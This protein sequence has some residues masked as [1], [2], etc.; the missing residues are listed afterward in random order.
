MSR[1]QLPKKYLKDTLTAINQ[2]VPNKSSNPSLMLVNLKTEGDKLTLSGTNQVVDISRDLS[3]DIEGQVNVN[4]PCEIFTKNVSVL[5]SELVELNFEENNLNIRSGP[6]KSNLTLSTAE[7]WQL[8][9]EFE[10]KFSIDG[11]ELQK[12][13]NHTNYAP[14]VAEYQ[15]VFRGVLFE[16]TGKEFNLVTTDGFRLAKYSLTESKGFPELKKVVF[17]DALQKI[18]KQIS[19]E[20]QLAFSNSHMLIESGNQKIKLQLMEGEY[21]DYKKVIP[22]QYV[23]EIEVDAEKFCRA[24]ENVSIMSDKSTNQRVDIQ[25]KGNTATITGEGGSGDAEQ[26]MELASIQGQEKEITLAYNSKYLVDALKRTA[27]TAKLSFSGTTSPSIITSIQD[28]NY[29]AMV[30]P[31]RD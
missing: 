18:Q 19:G 14:A 25:I 2:V 21:P 8:D 27:G 10:D 16:L 12:A 4:V 24:V 26:I 7:M 5:Q 23:T 1:I 9:F 6:Q 15:A 28:P 29:L 3:A 31:L 30:V 17:A 11:D 13:M 22:H 20:V